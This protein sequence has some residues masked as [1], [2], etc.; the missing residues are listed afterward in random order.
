M[1]ESLRVQVAIFAAELEQYDVAIPIFE[2]TAR[3]AVANNLLKFSAR[4]HLLNA[5]ICQLCSG[6]CHT[7]HSPPGRAWHR[8]S[9][10]L[11]LSRGVE[12]PE[13][14]EFIR[15]YQMQVHHLRAFILTLSVVTTFLTFGYQCIIR[16]TNI[17]CEACCNNLELHQN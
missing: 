16:E 15:L 11:G 3:A 1:A 5:G 12:D 7:L 9:V 2:D 14:E 13:K 10:H 8:I 6:S 4:G 17:D